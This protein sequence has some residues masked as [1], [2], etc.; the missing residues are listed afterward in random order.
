MKAE[1][2]LLGFDVRQTTSADAPEWD[3][4]RREDFLF[5]AD[6]LRPLSTDPTVWPS[7]GGNTLRIASSPGH[8]DL[9]SD[10]QSLQ[11]YVSALD[12]TVASR[13]AVIAVTLHLSGGDEAEQNY[14]HTQ[15]P[16]PT[17]ST[18]Q[19]GWSFLG[20][21]VSD[22]WLL[23]GLSNCG[24][25]A[26]QDDTQALKQQWSQKLNAHHLFDKL[27]DAIEFKGL[28]NRRVVEHSPFF[29]FGIWL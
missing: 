27:E 8:Q 15:V 20:Y 18:R 5:R 13:S 25:V 3:A 29:V 11:S 16:H 21:D 28:S 2:L 9:W 19:A 14:W 17:P 12:K 1:E 4:Q 6:V 7:L 10:L 26:A 24:F 22:R 23:S